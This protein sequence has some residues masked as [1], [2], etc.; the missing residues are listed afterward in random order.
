MS[1]LG[2]HVVVVNCKDIAMLGERHWEHKIYRHH[3]G[4]P[5]GFREKTARQVWEKDIGNTRYTDIIQDFQEGFVR[6][7]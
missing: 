1:D 3:T 5:G 4:F 6:R 7:L 2:D